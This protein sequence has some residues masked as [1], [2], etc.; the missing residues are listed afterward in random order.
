MKEK[1]WRRI[2]ALRLGVRLRKNE[3]TQR[4]LA[5]RIGVTPGAISQY[6][7]G[8]RRPDITTVVNMAHAFDCT[9]HELIDVGEEITD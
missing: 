4:E 7:T 3:M 2:F 6:L 9:V 5:R 8:E 1:D